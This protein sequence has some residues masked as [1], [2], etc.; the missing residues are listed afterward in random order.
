[1]ILDDPST[2]HFG[3]NEG[4]AI[5]A[6]LRDAVG[7]SLES[8][9]AEEDRKRREIPPPPPPCGR[10]QELERYAEAV[11]GSRGWR[12]LQLLRGLFGRSW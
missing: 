4:Q 3:S 1:V 9:L 7:T 2:G 12:F 10:C 8:R 5:I 11:Q 6:V